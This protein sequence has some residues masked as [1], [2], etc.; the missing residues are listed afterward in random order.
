MAITAACVWSYVTTFRST[1]VLQRWCGCTTNEEHCQTCIWDAVHSSTVLFFGVNIIGHYSWCAFSSPGFVV[2]DG[3]A[4]NSSSSEPDNRCSGPAKT[5]FGGCCFLSS[6]INLKEEQERCTKYNNHYSR[7]VAEQDASLDQT[8]MFH[9]SPNPTYC[10]K[11]KHDR[12]PRS[13][14]CKVC[15]RCV[16]EFDHHC[17]WVNNCIGFGNYREF[18]LLLVYIILGCA[19]GCCLLASDFY[20]TMLNHFE[21]H[22]FKL[23]GAKH[24]TGLLDLPPPWV[25]WREYQSNGKID[26]DEVLR[27]VF[28]FMVFISI[29]MA[30]ILVPHLKLIV[31]GYTTVEQLSRPGVGAV[32]NPFDDGPKKN[33]QRIM[34]TSVVR[35]LLPLP[36]HTRLLLNQSYGQRFKDR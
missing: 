17:P 20:S 4:S 6:K 24:G 7:I 8:I 13:H 36:A 21:V 26:D 1:V 23:L 12:P 3:G 33:L 10:T 35:L 9:P 34:G 29:G 2:N 27:A 22:G 32:K 16:L 18:I 15:A 11:C 19:Y 31:S 25:L 30:C 28:P 14:H 5:R